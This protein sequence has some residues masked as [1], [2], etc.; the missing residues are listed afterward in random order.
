MSLHLP[1]R[2]HIDPEMLGL[3]V[4]LLLPLGCILFTLW[5]M[6]ALTAVMGVLP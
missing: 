1:H 6:H 4:V 5:L 3:L 2:P